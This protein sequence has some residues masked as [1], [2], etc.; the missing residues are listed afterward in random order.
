MV[1][2]TRYTFSDLQAVLKSPKF[3]EMNEVLDGLG[4]GANGP[5]IPPSAMFSVIPFPVK[6]KAPVSEAANHYLFVASGPDDPY[7]HS[8]IANGCCHA[9][10]PYPHMASSS[11]TC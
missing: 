2:M 8:G 1:W 7:V 5:P 4:L 3:P 10:F 6:R 11:E 9:A